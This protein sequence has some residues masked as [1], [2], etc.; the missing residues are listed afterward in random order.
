MRRE[1]LD[2]LNGVDW[3]RCDIGTISVHQR[4]VG[5]HRS[6]PE[7]IAG[8]DEG[9]IQEDLV[10]R[11]RPCHRRWHSLMILSMLYTSLLWPSLPVQDSTGDG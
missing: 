11:D 3:T 1:L 10:E 7:I 6:L 5:E 9:H 2:Y 4:A 8:L